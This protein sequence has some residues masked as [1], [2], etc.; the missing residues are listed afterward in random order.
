MDDL[1]QL[2]SFIMPNPLTFDIV[3]AH[4][5][6]GD[7][8]LLNVLDKFSIGQRTK[9]LEEIDSALSK[10]SGQK[11]RAAVQEC[12]HKN[13]Q[14]V[15]WLDPDYPTAF[16][17]LQSTAP[18]VLYLQGN[19]DLLSCASVAVIG[20][21]APSAYGKIAAAEWSK[22]FARQNL[23]IISGNAKGIDTIAHKAALYAGGQTVFFPF[24]SVDEFR[25]GFLSP[26]LTSDNHLVITPFPP[27]ATI[28]KGAF[29]RRNTLVAA[30]CKAAII[31][32]TGVRGGTLD[33]IAKLKD[34][35]K[36]R[37]IV[38]MPPDA[39]RHEAHSRLLSYM[40]GSIPHSPDTPTFETVLSAVNNFN[41]PGKLILTHIDD[42]FEGHL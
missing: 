30:F 37:F 38:E 3:A 1:C 12:N 36:P 24:T 6:L 9:A 39:P 26:L 35:G 4:V 17:Y 21:R 10:P 25:P 31:A 40:T 28:H 32:D 18:P 5:R 27:T 34:Q 41:Y 42:F 14:V 7:Q 23:T 22:Q 11:L 16:R 19:M 2:F 20:S 8:N 13:V 29:L 33:T 15:T